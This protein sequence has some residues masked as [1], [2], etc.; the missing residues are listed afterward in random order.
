MS[1]PDLKQKDLEEVDRLVAIATVC[2]TDHT[3]QQPKLSNIRVSAIERAAEIMG[4]REGKENNEET[5]KD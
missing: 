3:A 4:I 1:R 2:K 5:D